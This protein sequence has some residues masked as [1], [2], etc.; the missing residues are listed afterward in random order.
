MSPGR[1]RCYPTVQCSQSR[2]EAIR[3]SGGDGRKRTYLLRIT[4]GDLTKVL[5]VTELSQVWD[6]GQL[7]IVCRGTKVFE[8]GG[9]GSLVET[10]GRDTV[11]AVLDLAAKLAGQG[12]KN[13]HIR[14]QSCRKGDSMGA[15]LDHCLF[16]RVLSLYLGETDED[17]K[18]AEERTFYRRPTTEEDSTTGAAWIWQLRRR[19]PN[20]RPGYMLRS[21]S[22]VIETTPDRQAWT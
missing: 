20:I 14:K 6:V 21:S 17:R 9:K 8:A 1:A 12:K 5:R 3:L 16:G 11:A 15:K 4:G 19:F 7:S 13:E 18:M 10:K 22:R 2:F